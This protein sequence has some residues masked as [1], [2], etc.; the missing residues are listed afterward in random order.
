MYNAVEMLGYVSGQKSLSYRLQLQAP[1]LPRDYAPAGG[2]LGTGYSLTWGRK[3][4][5]ADKV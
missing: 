4:W 5:A 2:T 1:L 3:A